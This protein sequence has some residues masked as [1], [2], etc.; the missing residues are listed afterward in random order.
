MLPFSPIRFST[1][2]KPAAFFLLA[3]SLLFALPARTTPAAEF[4]S[5]NP[6]PRSFLD[7]NGV[8]PAQD[9]GKLRLTADLGSVRIFSLAPGEAPVV[10]YSVH[11]ET[12]AP[13]PQAQQ[14]LSQYSLKAESTPDGVRIEGAL[15][16]KN[17]RDSSPAQFWVRFDVFVPRN[18]SVEVLTAG[19]DI[20]T[21]DIGGMA[22]LV[23]G[24]GSIRCGQLASSGK[25][26]SSGKPAAYLE[27]QGG[28]ITI[29]DVAGELYASTGGGH[30]QVREISGNAT[31]HSGGGHIRAARIGGQ[32]DLSTGGGNITVGQAGAAVSVHTAGGQID[33]GEARGSVQAR[34]GGG[35]IRVA[36][37]SGPL[38]IETSGGSICLT[39]IAGSVSA[40]TS[41]GAITAFINPDAAPAG[42]AV[43]LAGDSL[44]SSRSGDLR[45]YLPRNLAANIEA[46]VANGGADRIQA[47]PSLPLTLLPE[48]PAGSPLRATASLNGGGALL[49][50]R[51]GG[52]NIRL[53]YLDSDIALRQS[54]LREQAQRI[55]E[56][57]LEIHREMAARMSGFQQAGL[58]QPAT[59]SP[60]LAQDDSSD[61]G[62]WMAFWREVEEK[63]RG[64]IGADP[65]ELQK[66]AVFA[67]PPVYPPL[68]QKAGIQGAVRLAIRVDKNGNTEV[69]KILEGEP[70]LADA[71]I[72]AVKQWRYRP[73]RLNGGAVNLISEVT[74]TFVL[75]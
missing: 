63:L 12:S 33:F 32:A 47:D 46:E 34:T 59:P 71:A 55:E 66:R 74:F 36:S 22:R 6:A 68:A 41:N 48:G 64:G 51:T 19:G 57:M 7:R 70:V 25:F 67:P 52:G 61:L 13:E 53:Q 37:A 75:H 38:Q 17:R 44:L 10:R 16:L 40:S 45:V 43:Q 28:H 1:R 3:A 54:L 11:I 35:G 26:A 30:V 18:F 8:L 50:L 72:A 5:P 31:L 23:T 65:T 58:Q 56:R 69:L 73:Q 24:G 27:T 15:P 20:E 21:Q 4:A 9:G 14:L 42:G 49:R 2:R 29:G 60:A 62:A 39:R